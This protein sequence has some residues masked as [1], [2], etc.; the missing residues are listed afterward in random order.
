MA[1]PA[2]LRDNAAHYFAKLVTAQKGIP[3]AS[4]VSALVFL[5][6]SALTYE[7]PDNLT[8][9]Q[10]ATVVEEIRNDLAIFREEYRG[11]KYLDVIED[12]NNK[13]LTAFTAR[14]RL[15]LETVN[16]FHDDVRPVL[17][18]ILFDGNL[19][20]QQAKELMQEFSDNI[21]P[22]QKISEHLHI[23]DFGRLREHR[24]TALQNPE[25]DTVGKVLA[26]TASENKM[27]NTAGFVLPML[28]AAFLFIGLAADIPEDRRLQRLAREKPKRPPHFKH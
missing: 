7:A 25:N 22:P 19:S 18:R 28:L 26:A 5:V 8:T 24:H 6:P 16:K 17:E 2:R 12:Y 20:E 21:K 27:I 11:I 14:Q 9:E 3:A 15:R 23:S 1:S 4:L 10:T 13:D